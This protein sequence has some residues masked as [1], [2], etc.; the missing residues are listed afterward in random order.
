MAQVKFVNIAKYKGVSH[1]A[2]TPFEVD[3]ADVASMVEQGAIVIVP[4]KGEQSTKVFIDEMKVDELKA[5]A[6][7]NNIDISKANKKADIVAAIKAAQCA[8]E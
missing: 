6:A 1:P 2:H 5:Y 8:E 4:P 3:D 7:S